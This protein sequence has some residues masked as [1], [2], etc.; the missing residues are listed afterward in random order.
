MLHQITIWGSKIC[1]YLYNQIRDSLFKTRCLF[2]S[3]YLFSLIQVIIQLYYLRITGVTLRR[4]VGA[5]PAGV[6][7]KRGLT[8]LHNTYTI[9]GLE[10][11]ATVRFALE[12]MFLRACL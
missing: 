10:S 8:V 3:S 4:T 7:V 11:N 12:I 2:D 9:P 6:C 1:I 5:G